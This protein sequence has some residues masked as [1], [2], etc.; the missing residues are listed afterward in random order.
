MTL[1]LFLTLLSGAL[2]SYRLFLEEMM[3]IER[4]R[5]RLSELLVEVKLLVSQQCAGQQ[6]RLSVYGDSLT[7]LQLDQR[8]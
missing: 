5:R 8:K 7:G 3:I 2:N 6:E 4:D 1:I